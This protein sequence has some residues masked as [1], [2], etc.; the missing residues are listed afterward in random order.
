[1]ATKPKGVPIHVPTPTPSGKGWKKTTPV[2][3]SGNSVASLALESPDPIILIDGEGRLLAVNDAA[4]HAGVP[5]ALAGLAPI[6]KLAPFWVDEV[7]REKLLETLRTKK[8]AENF[9]VRV[10]DDEGDRVYWVNAQ[11]LMPGSFDAIVAS[12]RDVTERTAEY[13]LLKVC[14]EELAARSDR[15]PITG[16]YNREQFHILVEREIDWSRQ[17][18]R[19][20]ALIHLDLDDFKSLNESL[21]H[22]AGDEY[23]SRLGD[24]LRD[25]FE[26][27]E[28]IGRVGGD[29]IGILFPETPAGGVGEKADRLLA[30]FQKL[31]PTFEG[32]ALNLTASM[33]AAIYPDHATTADELMHAADIAMNQAKRKGRARYQV[34]DPN[35][36]ETNRV[37]ALRSQVERIRIAIAEQR[38]VPVFQPVADIATGRIVA[39][40]TLARLREPDG[41]LAS[42]AEFLDAAERFGFVTAIDRLVIQAAF[43]ALISQRSRSI[44]DL[45]MAINLS[46]VDF[47]DDTLVADISRMARMK[48]IRP[49]RITFE[50]TETAALKD[51][52]RVQNFTRALVAE[53]FRFALDDFGIG[54]SSFKYLR[55]LPVSSL[56]FDQSYVMNLPT[57]MENRVFVRGMVEICRGLGVKTVG[58][59]VESQAI[60]SVLRELNVD[61]AQGYHIGLPL[62]ELPQA[63]TAVWA[64]PSSGSFKPIG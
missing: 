41:R 55:E 57:E 16:F 53:G 63:R 50:I 31:S 32:R 51:I 38:F 48:G 62:P 37:G 60:L 35:D 36:R 54:F 27:G 22:G 43:D 59:G 30:L 29:E 26:A 10:R 9:E 34:H 44:P 47:E 3:A 23:L 45:D 39:V 6:G 2:G 19:P 46:G 61:R 5:P 13:E 58:E 17:L 49:E 15:D 33:G 24:A 7:M 56:K 14:Y 12:A 20:I 11:P 40:E 25:E 18:S 64:R 28:V 42:P 52:A 21:G 4:S 1:M 8:R